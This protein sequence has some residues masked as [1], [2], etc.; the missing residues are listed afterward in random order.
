MDTSSI[1]QLEEFLERARRSAELL[2]D[3]VSGSK[4]PPIAGLTAV[5]TDMLFIRL[6]EQVAIRLGIELDCLDGVATS[7]ELLG[8]VTNQE[9]ASLLRDEFLKSTPN[10]RELQESF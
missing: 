7:G 4:L 10:D 6:L 9:V 1:G 3:D 5:E 2:P 8:K